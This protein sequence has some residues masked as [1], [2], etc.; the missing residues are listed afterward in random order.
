MDIT[1]VAIL[2]CLGF[3]LAVASYSMLL[4]G[5]ASAGAAAGGKKK[6]KRY[7]KNKNKNKAKAK[8]NG[9][10]PEAKKANGKPADA[11]ED[12]SASKK[13]GSKGKLSRNQR[14]KRNIRARQAEEDKKEK[15][16]K[17][18]EKLNEGKKQKGGRKQKATP[19]KTA[20]PKNTKEKAKEAKR[21]WE[22]YQRDLADGWEVVGA[23]KL[24][25]PEA[26]N[27]KKNKKKA[28]AAKAAEQAKKQQAETA[29]NAGPATSIA[30][31]EVD[32]RHYGKIIGTGGV[33]LKAIIEK[34]NAM[35]RMPRRDAETPSKIVEIEGTGEAVGLAK[36]A[37]HELITKGYSRLLNPEIAEGTI[38][39]DPKLHGLIIGPKGSVI[40]A[41]K[42]KTGVN[43]TFPGSESKSRRITLSGSRDGIKAAKAAIKFIAQYKY[44]P[45]LSPGLTHAEVPVPEEKMGLIIGPKA[46]TRRHIEG[47]TKA[48]LHCPMRGDEKQNVIVVGTPEAV[49]RAKKAI[50]KILHKNEQEGDDQRFQEGFQEE[51]EEEETLDPTAAQYLVDTSR[52]SAEL[53]DEEEEGNNQA[54]NVPPEAFPTTGGDAKT[55]W[56]PSKASSKAASTEAA[57]KV[58]KDAD[59]DDW[60]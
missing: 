32:P 36:G 1:Q 29:A 40:N 60:E 10:A 20:S 5:K 54:W 33:T 49:E 47:N 52:P 15:E 16:E 9:H 38:S 46:S 35:I 14:R 41:L 27:K 21:R 11:A 26:G 8:Q 17:L 56:G 31:I 48:K 28:Q 24:K 45:L 37:I 6:K 7:N 12:D 18:K 55:S 30:K 13:K 19:A 3:L 50:L 25:K 23:D 57:V 51:E 42:K 43:I 34:S 59:A 39:I 44:T 53:E 2:I 58:A 22:E 4:Q